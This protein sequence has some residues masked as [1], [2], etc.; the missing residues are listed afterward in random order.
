MALLA[1]FVERR[2]ACDPARHPGVEG[3]YLEA[4]RA[5]L[6]DA[7]FGGR[8]AAHRAGVHEKNPFQG[9]FLHQ[10]V[11]ARSPAMVTLLIRAGANPEA[12]EGSVGGTALHAAARGGDTAVCRALV[13][14]GAN[15]FAWDLDGDTPKGLAEI[16]EHAEAVA[17]FEEVER[18]RV[19]QDHYGP[20]VKP[21]P[22]GGAAPEPGAGM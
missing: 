1:G 20:G 22:P 6:T 16:G 18:D 3:Q 17:Y 7:R 9:R 2:R 8:F 15:P 4:A 19:D 12:G 21:P 14:A 13:E 5:L 11:L 10:A